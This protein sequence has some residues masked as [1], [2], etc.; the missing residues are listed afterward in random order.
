MDEKENP[1]LCDEALDQFGEFMRMVEDTLYLAEVETECAICLNVLQRPHVIDPCG[2]TFCQ[3]CLI[4]LSQ[5][6]GQNCPNCR[7]VINGTNLNLRLHL[8]LQNQHQD[9]YENRRREDLESG[10]YKQK[11][12]IEVNVPMDWTPYGPL[13]HVHIDQINFTMPRA[14]TALPHSD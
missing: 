8:A 14:A 6:Q 7:G 10:V 9:A 4:R 2:H 3:A 12:R 5:A 13:D 11:I 1:G